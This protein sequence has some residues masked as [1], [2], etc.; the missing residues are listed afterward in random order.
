[1]GGCSVLL[2]LDFLI[3]GRIDQGQR[4][5]FNQIRIKNSNEEL[6]KRRQQM[7]NYLEDRIK[8]L[9]QESH[10]IILMV[11]WNEDIQGR[12]FTKRSFSLAMA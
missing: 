3:C 2:L 4:D 5:R 9:E 10:W 6:A 12:K 11:D 7:L 8:A 1:V